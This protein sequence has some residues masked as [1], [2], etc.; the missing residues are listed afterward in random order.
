MIKINVILGD[1]I[2]KKYLSDPRNYIDKKL[3]I[4]NTKNKI[5]KKKTFT[6]SLLLSGSTEIKKLNIKFRKKNKSTDILSFPFHTKKILSKKIKKE[7]EI[8]LGDMIININKINNK[9][10]KIKFKENFNKLWVHGLVHLFGY[11]HKKDQDYLMMDRIEKK[12]LGYIK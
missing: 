4:L 10:N 1:N 9:N 5:Y 3:R 11:K 8:Y 6:C 12:Y 7:K 2:W